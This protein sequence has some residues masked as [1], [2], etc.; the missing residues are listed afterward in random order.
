MN[1]RKAP[2]AECP[3]RRDTP[4]GQFSAE[5]YEALRGTTGRPGNEVGFHAP[6]FA[7]HKSTEADALP[8]AG[9]LA[10]VGVESLKVRLLVISGDIPAS[11]LR[12]G[13]DWPELFDSYDAMERAQRR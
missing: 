8:C 5:R 6:L 11:A 1:V 3:W 9:W 12:P 10:A 13:D 2:C 4:S 7:C